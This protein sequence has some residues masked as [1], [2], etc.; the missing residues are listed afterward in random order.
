MSRIV[1]FAEYGTPGVLRVVDVLPPVPG[2]TQVR[3]AVRAAGVNPIDW[4][5]VAGYMRE[6]MPLELPAGVGSDVAGVVDAVGSEVTEWAVG[7]EVL[8]R[9]TTGSFADHALAES[10]DIVRKPAGVAWEVAGSLAGAGGTAYAVLKKLDVKPGETLL[11]H[12]AAGGVGTFA[13][14]IAKAQG[15][16]VI[17]TASESNHEYLRSLGATP[18]TYGDGLLE[19]VRAVAPEGVDAVLDASGRG[20][21]PL[22]IELTGNPARVLTLVA[23]DAAG[24]GIQ[25]HAGGAGSELGSALRELAA[26]AAQDR[27]VVSISR[28]YPLTEAAAALSASTTGHGH[29][30][31]AVVP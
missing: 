8:G 3:I 2:P 6:L 15:V 23:F 28:T 22:S 13:V 9:S 27:L 31:L 14:Q 30:K 21:I 26:L 12:A 10:A 16:N 18:V 29:G 24:T 4:K 20:E 25:V 19:R 17:G 7:D 11:I 5:I 1:Q